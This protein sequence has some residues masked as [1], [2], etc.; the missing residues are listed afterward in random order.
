MSSEINN[1]RF[2]NTSIPPIIIKRKISKD[3]LSK[4]II[5]SK[6]DWEEYAK[7]NHINQLKAK[8]ETFSAENKPSVSDMNLTYQRRNAFCKAK[9]IEEKQRLVAKWK[10]EDAKKKTSEVGQ[11]Q[12]NG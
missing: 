11:N 5:R 1:S 4:L 6:R 7:T 3:T 10:K 12:L 9:T 2:N 8:M